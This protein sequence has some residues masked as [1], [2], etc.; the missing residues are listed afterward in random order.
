VLQ[1]RLLKSERARN[2]AEAAAELNADARLPNNSVPS[3]DEMR[4]DP[5]YA[6]IWRREQAR[7]F[8][9]QYADAF[10]D[11]KLPGAQL[12]KFL[13]L[14]IDRKAA[15]LDAEEAART[16]NLS[17][18]EAAAAMKRSSDE[19]TDEIKGLLGPEA[20]QQFGD[21]T[22]T[23][24]AKAWFNNAVG[25]DAE[26]AGA[27]FTADQT[28]LLAQAYLDFRQVVKDPE[29]S[30]NAAPD[31]TTGLNPYFQS[32]LERFA[33][34][35]TPAQLPVMRTYFQDQVTANQYWVQTHSPAK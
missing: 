12:S 31:P 3:F 14:L 23:S 27:P 32:L 28:T 19:V 21:A 7:R 5:R 10:A 4:K 20:Y 26:A 16:E 35:L 29:N 1:A 30:P 13:D 8:R 34:Q 22:K 9:L 33:P 2:A 11:L 24:D 18:S 15:S 17:A 6:A 25:V